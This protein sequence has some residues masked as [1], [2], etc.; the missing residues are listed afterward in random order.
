MDQRSQNDELERIDTGDRTV[1]RRAFFSRARLGLLGATGVVL[2]GI[3]TSTGGVSAD[4]ESEKEKKKTEEPRDKDREAKEKEKEKDDKPKEKQ[5]KKSDEND[6]NKSN[7]KRKKH[8]NGDA[9]TKK[10][11]ADPAPASPYATDVGKK[12]DRFG[13]TDFAAQSE[14]QQVLRLEPKD[15]NNLDGNRNGIACDGQD[16]FMDGVAGGLMKPP[17]DL[18]PV[19]RP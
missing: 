15:P 11:K 7:T 10:K 19:S 3:A 13:C 2:F 17:F 9:S 5:S 1:S 4:E 18:T 8:K 16:A 12:N 6:G 14:A